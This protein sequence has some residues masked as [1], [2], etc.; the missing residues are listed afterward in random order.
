[1]DKALG[2]KMYNRGIRAYKLIYE[3]I[4]SKVI[5]DQVEI[6]ECLLQS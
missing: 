4:I 6:G 1:M 2:R 3:A 5:L